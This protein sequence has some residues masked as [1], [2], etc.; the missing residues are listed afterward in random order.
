MSRFSQIDPSEEGP[1]QDLL[2]QVQAQLGKVPNLYRA[3]AHSREALAGYLAFRAALQTGSLTTREREQ[4]ALRVA[5][6]NGCT[7]CISAHAFRGKRLGIDAEELTR[8]RNGDAT[9]PHESA[10]LRLATAIFQRRGGLTDAEVE[11]GRD[12]GVD[13]AQVA[14]IVAHVALNIFSNYFNHVARPDLDF[15]LIEAAHA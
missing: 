3:M 1:S 12:A 14:E 13:D 4:V 8:I 15:P 7:Y 9:D 5:E 2:G 6:L 11:Q 10:V